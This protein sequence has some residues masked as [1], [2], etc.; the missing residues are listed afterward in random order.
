[1]KVWIVSFGG[2]CC[3]TVMESMRNQNISVNSTVDGDKLKH[4]YSPRSKAYNDHVHSF[5][6]IIYIYN[7]PLLAVLSMFR[8]GWAHGQHIKINHHP[9]ISKM[10]CDNF[11]LLQNYTISKN[12]EVFGCLTHFN[13]WN[14]FQH[15]I[16]ILFVDMRDHNSIREINTFL[17][18]DVKIDI[19]KRSSNKSTC[20]NEFV[21]LYDKVDRMI[22]DKIK[23][24]K[25]IHM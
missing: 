15:K 8:R 1:M 5:D 6:K 11:Q 9:T 14:T 7:D 4:L 25:N 22:V 21:D 20:K 16:P 10:I 12:E 17:N 3:T 13:E 24:K 18:S 2:V 19:K 23:S